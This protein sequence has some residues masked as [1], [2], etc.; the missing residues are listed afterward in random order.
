MIVKL[1]T[2]TPRLTEFQ[3]T[4]FKKKKKKFDNIFKT[5][6]ERGEM[7]VAENAAGQWHMFLGGYAAADQ[8][9]V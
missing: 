3:V 2:G 7:T 4:L 8:G 1:F 9:P 5:R 6:T